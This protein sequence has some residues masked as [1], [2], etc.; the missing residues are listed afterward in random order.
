M[1]VS[2]DQAISI[3]ARALKGRAGKKSPMLARLRANNLKERGD[4][5]GYHVWTQVSERA[6]QLLA[7]QGETA[8]E[9]PETE[10][11]H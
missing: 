2:L 6:A 9:L 11:T 1:N 3:H 5:E 10:M 8:P 7:A 4:I